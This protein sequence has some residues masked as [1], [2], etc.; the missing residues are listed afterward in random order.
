MIVSLSIIDPDVEN[1]PY[2][3]VKETMVSFIG[4]LHYGYKGKYLATL[5][6]RY[7]GASQLVEK[8]DFFP[9]VSVAWKISEEEFMKGIEPVSN[10]KLRIGYGQTGNS[11]VKPYQ[12]MGSTTGY[13]MYYQFGVTETTIKGFRTGQLSTIPRWESTTAGNLGLDFGLFRN[14]ISGSLELYTVHTYDIL[15]EVTLPPT[16]AVGTVLENI[17]ETKGKGVELTLN[18]V[19]INTSDF[20]WST[21][22]PSREVRKKLLTWQGV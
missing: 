6:G 9:S 20:K 15:Q 3:Y 14:R 21:S 16:S 1:H 13:Q 10:L 12:S 2:P 18:T 22:L 8:W 4:R 7:D 17:G 5:T 19:N 11:S